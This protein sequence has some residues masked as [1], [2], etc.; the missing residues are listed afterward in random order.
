VSAGTV[1]TAQR[2]VAGVAAFGFFFAPLSLYVVGVRPVAFEN[3]ELARAPSPEDG[4]SGLDVASAW[5]TDH[6]PGRLQAV[7]A[8]AWLNYNVLDELPRETSTQTAGPGPVQPV[9]TSTPAEPP[10]FTAVRG[11]DG[12]FFLGSEFTAACEFSDHFAA[13]MR[14][15]AKTA[16]IVEASGRTIV[17]SVAPNKSSVT[18]AELPEAVPHGACAAHG[19]RAENAVMDSFR[20]PRYLS[21][22]ADLAAAHSSGRQVY[23]R[24]DSHWTTLGG[25][26]YA[27][28]LAR[29]LAPALAPR[30]EVRRGRLTKVG[31]LARLTGLTSTETVPS[32]VLTTTGTVREDP[33]S[34]GYDLANPVYDSQRWTTRPSDGLVTGRT[35]LVGDSFTYATLPTLRPLFARGTFVWIGY[36]SEREIIAEIVRSDTVV[37]SLAQRSVVTHLITTER[38][39]RRLAA[40]LRAA[41]R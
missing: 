34:P 33:G 40:R 23:W 20:H 26:I 38:F 7:R 18:T 36:S 19:I 14:A 32:T 15:W 10:A 17:F 11:K 16:E 27:R 1:Q 5:A 6:L 37:M 30:I 4:W 39:Q 24:T 13:S 22:R 35:V 9:P 12:Y 2:L 8:D 31:D 28:A 3:R 25:A 41:G 29:E 21:L